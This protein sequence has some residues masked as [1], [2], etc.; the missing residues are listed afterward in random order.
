MAR[1]PANAPESAGDEAPRPVGLHHSGQQSKPG[2]G[3]NGEESHVTLIAF[4]SPNSGGRGNRLPACG[5]RRLA[6][7]LVGEKDHHGPD[8]LHQAKSPEPGKGDQGDTGGAIDVGEDYLPAGSARLIGQEH[9]DFPVLVRHLPGEARG[10][11][12]PGLFFDIQ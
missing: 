10:E 11:P 7:Q 6:H 9:D 4:D 1:A 3:P 8:S 12:R 5:R 2:I